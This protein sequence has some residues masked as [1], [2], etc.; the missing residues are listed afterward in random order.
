MLTTIQKLNL[1]GKAPNTLQSSKKI[2]KLK[3]K[4]KVYVTCKNNSQQ[5]LH[6]KSIIIT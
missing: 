2:Q 1:Y 3:L 6:M 4:R 5:Y